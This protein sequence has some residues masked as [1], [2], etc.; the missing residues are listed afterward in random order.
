VERQ[1]AAFETSRAIAVGRAVAREVE[2]NRSG[3]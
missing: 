3:K 2:D 1:S